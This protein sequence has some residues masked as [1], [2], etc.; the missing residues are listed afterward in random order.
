MVSLATQPTHMMSDRLRFEVVMASNRRGFCPM[1][2]CNLVW[3]SYLR[4]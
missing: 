3:G 1:K 2:P 4:S